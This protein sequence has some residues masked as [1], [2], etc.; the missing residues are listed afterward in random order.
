MANRRSAAAATSPGALWSLLAREVV[1]VVAPGASGDLFLL[2]IADGTLADPEI[3]T[4]RIVEA[5]ALLQHDSRYGDWWPSPMP[6]GDCEQ[7][8]DCPAG[9]GENWHEIIARSIRA[10][11]S[12]GQHDDNG[13]PLA[14][15]LSPDEAHDLG[16][17]PEWFDYP[18]ERGLALAVR[19]HAHV[20][21][22]E[23]TVLRGLTELIDLLSTFGL[24]RTDD[25]VWIVP[26]ILREF[27]RECLQSA[28]RGRGY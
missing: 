27:A 15:G 16:F 21:I 3:G 24:Q 18:A 17:V 26:P 10:A 7:A 4:R 14:A 8:C 11:A 5:L 23:A 9:A 20:S 22:D 2:A 1:R 12:H 28:A 25:G 13:W 19:T 6:T